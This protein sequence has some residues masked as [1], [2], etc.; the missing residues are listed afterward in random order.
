MLLR[1]FCSLFFCYG[2]CVLHAQSIIPRFE[3][4]GVNDGLAH[5]SVNSITQD[6]KG[7]MWFG[8]PDG[9]CRYDGTELRSFKYNAASADDVINNFVRGQILEDK[10]GNIW[11]S[12][13]SGIYKWD[14]YK[15]QVVKVRPFKKE[16]FA[17]KG[18][19]N[20]FIIGWSFVNK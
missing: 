6:K 16:E 3:S 19:P 14:V 10:E 17:S 20:T 5:S 13:E 15:E 7:F 9:L 8:T 4:L 18:I 2:I 11:Y 12:N 1:I